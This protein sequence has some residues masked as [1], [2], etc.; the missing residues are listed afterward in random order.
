MHVFDAL[1]TLQL[2]VS[3]IYDQ[4]TLDNIRSSYN[5]VLRMDKI[6]QIFFRQSFPPYGIATDNCKLRCKIN[7]QYDFNHEC[8]TANIDEPFYSRGRFLS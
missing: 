1:T 8:L 7:V 2:L 3:N 5:F 4:V 6:R